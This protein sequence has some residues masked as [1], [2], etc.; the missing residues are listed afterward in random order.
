MGYCWN[1]FCFECWKTIEKTS[2]YIIFHYIL[3]KHLEMVNVPANHV[4]LPG[5]RHRFQCRFYCSVSANG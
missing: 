1:I 3:F 2:I 5:V 4:G